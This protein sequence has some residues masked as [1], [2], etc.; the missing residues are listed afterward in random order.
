MDRVYLD[1][2]ST[3]PTRP[4]AI[5]AITALLAEP[6]GD[7]GRI[8]HEGMTSRALVEHARSQVA[9]LLGTRSR[10]VVFTSGATESI[11]AAVFGAAERGSHMVVPKIEHSA[12][13]LQAERQC[14]V[15]PVDVDAHG[16]VD[17][18]EV[19]AAIRPDTAL[20]NL[21]WGNHEIGTTQPVDAVAV[22]CRDRD[23]LL[24]VDA[25][26]AVGQVPVDFGAL[27][28]DLLSFSGHKFGAPPGTGGLL[29]RRGLRIRPLLVGGEQERLRRAG[30]ENIAAIAGLGSACEVLAD[31]SLSR[32][33]VESR[34]FTDR[35]LNSVPEL[36]GVCV[37]GDP[38]G[39]L[40]QI[41]C[42]GISGIE[43]QA[44]L[45]GLDR[46]GIAVHSG[47]SCA[48]ESLEPSPVLEAMGVDAHHSLRISVGWNTTDGDI[49][50][51][52]TALPDVIAELRGLGGST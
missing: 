35:V 26:Q 43:P 46:R 41:L 36:D 47:N 27:G 20:V 49:D 48:S 14:S 40:P 28:I 5:E 39:R 21:Q 17:A 19:I 15:T 33:A 1:H 18:D 12:V 44:V 11:A 34:R 42:L 29:I 9:D 37:Y 38:V 45:L 24:H 51:L 8:H 30:F 7:P 3:S 4:E 6:T 23:V 32:G 50:A 10:E 52:L 16:R 25:A 2:A 22:A 31:G 13:R